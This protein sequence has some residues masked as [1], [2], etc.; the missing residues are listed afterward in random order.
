V[1]F[2][3]QVWL[4]SF[5]SLFSYVLVYFVRSFFS[6]FFFLCLDSSLFPLSLFLYYVSLF[7]YAFRYFGI[8]VSFC[9]SVVMYVLISFVF[10]SLCAYLFRYVFISLVIS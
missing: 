4:C 5:S 1:L 7:L 2:F 10:I 3:R 6:L 9:S 8:Y